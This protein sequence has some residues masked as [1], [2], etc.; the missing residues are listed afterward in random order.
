MNERDKQV[1]D[2]L[3]E[4]TPAQPRALPEQPAMLHEIRGPARVWQRRLAVAAGIAI[5]TAGAAWFA[6]RIPASLPSKVVQPQAETTQINAPAGKNPAALMLTKFA[7][8]DPARF[9]EALSATTPTGL[10]RFDRPNSALHA[11]A[12]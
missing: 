3:R 4:F 10:P 7:R 1:E 11:L 8:E 9:D 5:A 6:S 12:Q 2:F